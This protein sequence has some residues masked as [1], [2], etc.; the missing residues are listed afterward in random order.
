[1]AVGGSFK[2]LRILILFT[3][4]IFAALTTL[5]YAVGLLT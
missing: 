3:L 2:R 5:A 1:V 4:T